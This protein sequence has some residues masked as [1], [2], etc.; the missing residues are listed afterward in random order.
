MA[1]TAYTCLV[2]EQACTTHE[3]SHGS[4]IEVLSLLLH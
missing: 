3:D 2:T 1:H 4:A